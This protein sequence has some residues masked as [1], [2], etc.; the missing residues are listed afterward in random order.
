MKVFIRTS[1]L[2]AGNVALYRNLLPPRV[3]DRLDTLS[4]PFNR[5]PTPGVRLSIMS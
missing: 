5:Q 3:T 1:V 2:S 4:C